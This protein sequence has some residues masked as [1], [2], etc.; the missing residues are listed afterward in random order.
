MPGEQ[1]VEDHGIVSLLKD[2]A[3]GLGQ[4]VADHL[5]LARAE[6]AEDVKEHT[7]RLELRGLAVSLLLLGYALAS[8]AAALEL[9]RLL[10][11][12]SGFLVVSAA[13]LLAGIV[14]LSITPRR[15]RARRLLSESRNELTRTANSLTARIG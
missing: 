10:T 8:V 7:R 13:N 2:A 14:M 4:L 6:L 15:F 11:P 1:S 5:R 9:A 3:Q 12:V